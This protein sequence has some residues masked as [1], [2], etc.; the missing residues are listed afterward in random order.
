V[1]AA[2]E[3]ILYIPNEPLASHWYCVYRRRTTTLFWRERC[4]RENIRNYSSNTL[5]AIL[6]WTLDLSNTGILREH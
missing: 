3:L 1:A 5:V 6:K 4:R 2:T